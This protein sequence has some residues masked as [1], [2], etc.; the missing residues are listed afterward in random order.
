MAEVEPRLWVALRESISLTARSYE[1]HPRDS[2]FVFFTEDAAPIRPLLGAVNVAAGIAQSTLGLLTWPFDRGR[3]LVGGLKGV[4][5]SLPE[6]AFVN[7]RKGTNEILPPATMSEE[8]SAAAGEGPPSQGREKM[9]LQPPNG[10]RP[11]VFA[12]R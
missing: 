7:I 8:A 10:F 11:A 1:P 4:A 9:S 5:V 6:L 3:R 2:F 12:S